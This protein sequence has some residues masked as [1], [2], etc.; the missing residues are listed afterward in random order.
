MWSGR[1]F[2]LTGCRAQR[3]PDRLVLLLPKFLVS[4]SAAAV[5]MV[6]YRTMHEL[7]LLS[8]FI[9]CTAPTAGNHERHTQFCYVQTMAQLIICLVQLMHGCASSALHACRCQQDT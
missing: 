1:G 8:K 4:M 6:L 9:Q 5:K 7:I 3:T 2:Q